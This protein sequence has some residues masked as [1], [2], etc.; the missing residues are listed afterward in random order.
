MN[1]SNWTWP[2][3]FIHFLPRQEEVFGLTPTI[4]AVALQ[5]VSLSIKSEG[6]TIDT[7]S[8]TVMCDSRTHCITKVS[9]SLLALHHLVT[10]LKISTSGTKKVFLCNNL[11]TDSC[12]NHVIVFHYKDSYWVG[13]LDKWLKQSSATIFEEFSSINVWQASLNSS[14]SRE[15]ATFK[16]VYTFSR[17]KMDWSFA[18]TAFCMF[19]NEYCWARS[20]ASRINFALEVIAPGTNH[21]EKAKYEC[22]RTCV[23][24]SQ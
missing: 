11:I 12:N 23:N 7:I 20:N 9:K 3:F 18:T 17:S 24:K 13:T 4:S 6:R 22:E 10:L 8:A 14:R 16:M 19:L 5:R 1:L 21:R 15:L 2:I